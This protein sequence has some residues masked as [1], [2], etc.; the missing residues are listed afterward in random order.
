MTIVSL[1]EVGEH[2]LIDY[3]LHFNV[4]GVFIMPAKLNPH[5]TVIS[6][7]QNQDTIISFFVANAPAVEQ[8]GG[9]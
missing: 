7:Y 2:Q 8:V 1:F 6:R 3:A 9:E 5:F 4:V